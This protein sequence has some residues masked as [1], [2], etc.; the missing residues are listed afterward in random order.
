MKKVILGFVVLLLVGLTGAAVYVMNID[1]NQH[2]DKIAEQFYNS[3]GKIISFDGRL[4]F[5][6]F[7]SPYLN[8]LDA[9]IYN[10]DNK[11]KK[12]LLEIKNVVAELALM[13]L[14]KG[15]I[16]VKKMILDGVVINIDW[17]DEG[18]SWQSDLSP[19][20]RQM[21]EDN[22]LILNSVSLKNAELNFEDSSSGV[23]FKLTNLNGEIFA[24]SV[25]GPFRIEG[26]YVKGSSPEGFALSIGKLSENMATTFNMAITHPISESYVRFDGSFHLI[27]KVLNGN[28]IVESQKVADFINANF[29]RANIPNE[30]NKPAALGFDIALNPQKLSLS[31][32][33]LK[34]DGTQGAGVLDM[35]LNDDT[36]EITTEF[37]FSDMNLKPLVDLF[38]NVME[39]YK[40][41][42]FVANYPIAL[43]AVVKVL[44]PFYQ[45]QGFKNLDIELALSGDGVTVDNFSIVLP[46]NTEL[47]LKGNIYSNDGELYYNADVRAA[48]NDLSQTL[49]W[50]E[51]NPKANAVSVYKKMLADMKIAG[52][53]D[54][55]QI[56]PYK[57]TMDKSTLTGE[58]GVIL[59]DRMDIMLVVNADTINFDNYISSIPEE[60]KAKNWFERMVYRFGKL[61]ILNDFDLVLDAKAGLLIYESMPFEKVDFKGNILNGNMEIEYAKIEKMA[62]TSLGLKGNVSGFGM[63]PK[64]DNLQ[65]EINS[66]DVA[67]LINK[68]ELNVPDLDYKKFNNLSMSG[69][70]NGQVD[71]FG[72]NTLFT[73]GKLNANYEGFISEYDGNFGFDGEMEVKHP[74]FSTLLNNLKI[75]YQPNSANSGIFKLKAKIAGNENSLVLD[76]MEANVGYTA[77]SGNISFENLAER[78]MILGKLNVNKFEIDKFL[79]KTDVSGILA[80]PKGD[81][82]AFLQ[83]PFFSKTKIDY[84]PYIYADVKVDLNVNELSYQNYIMK[85]SKFNLELVDGNLSIK[86]F[87]GIYNNSPLQARLSWYMRENP[88]I[89]VGVK[90]TDAKTNDFAIGGNV[91][92]LKGGIFSTQFDFSSKAD[93]G[94]SFIDNLSGKALLSASSVEVGGINLEGIY[95]DLTQRDKSEGLAE[96]VK[97]FVGSGKTLFAKVSGRAIFENGQYSLADVS[98]S[99]DNANIKVYGDGSLSNWDM[100]VVFNTKYSEPKYL[101]E[102]SFSLKN[103]MESPIIDVNVSSLFKLFQAKEEQRQA[104]KNAEIEAE[105]NYLKGLAEEQKK[106]ADNLLLSTREKLE[107]D[108]EE[109]MSTAVSPDNVNKYNILKQEIAQ[110]LAELVE[111]MGS[112]DNVSM[113]EASINK[114]KEANMNAVKQVEIFTNERDKIYL[115]DLKKQNETEFNKIVEMHNQLKQ[116][117]FNYN[118][119]MDKYTE[120]L[121][122]IITNY[123]LD[124]DQQFQ[125]LKKDIDAKIAEMEQ[126]NDEASKAQTLKKFD[127]TIAEYEEYNKKLIGIFTAIKN[128]RQ[129][130]LEKIKILE[131]YA[132]P[133]IEIEVKN[134]YEEQNRKEDQKKLEENTGTISI[135]RT[136]QTLT[137]TRDIEDIKNAEKE[138]SRN[139]VK[140]LDFSREKVDLD[141]KDDTMGKNMIKKGRNI[142]VN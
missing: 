55:L 37:N 107:K 134:Y 59:G 84:S 65:Y 40:N 132:S 25:F 45:E 41:E 23:A 24:Q 125:T 142:H 33:V 86:D 129:E 98:M 42:P 1:W 137:I 81:V 74:D 108:L 85:D 131:E 102:F 14:I 20:Q 140:V 46:G 96:S 106:L 43:N 61:G 97:S 27:N 64:V 21:M 16:H 7:P 9:K 60:E 91:Y 44:R 68:L 117:I 30:Y 112:V 89:N 110:L 72:I 138:I 80:Q 124:D 66:S 94:Q 50:L 38:K 95:R 92:N 82:A 39:K 11:N 122:A 29:V 120:Q 6:I 99:A 118:A 22:N 15:E 136:G 8:A 52:S 4:G 18:L 100:N 57:V 67:S 36:S 34:Y 88:T 77:A 115:D 123:N 126:L 69:M 105:Q 119:K 73:L 114:M 103:S 56:S 51:I 121:S 135:K 116:S 17:S 58:A 19:D 127:A 83:K 3:T 10:T 12:P 101:P 13:P 78:P 49:D 26:N 111:V 54:K 76:G 47:K 90:I 63:S 128:G 71:N 75:K 93:S 139:G 70:I 113:D 5:K 2:K 53:F 35:P 48:S 87:Y 62:N 79:P 109:K 130:L 32:I 104:A 141:K 31:N 133:K 28:I